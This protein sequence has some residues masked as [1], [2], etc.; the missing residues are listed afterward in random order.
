MVVVLRHALV[1]VGSLNHQNSY[2][3][4]L[5]AHIKCDIVQYTD[6]IYQYQLPFSI[7]YINAFV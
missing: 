5:R 7:Y 3:N 4:G 2:Q 6:Q 1:K